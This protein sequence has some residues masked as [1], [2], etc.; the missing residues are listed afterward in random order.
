VVITK[1]ATTTKSPESGSL[2]QIKITLEV[3]NKS[4][5]PL[6]GIL[7]SDLVPTIANV[8]RGLELGTLKP[9]EIKQTR[10]GTK[11]IWSL[12]ELDAHEHRI[13]TYKVRSKLNILGTFSLPRAV[14]EYHVGKRKRKA[15]SSVFKVSS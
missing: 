14:V 3:S 8:E 15:Y 1:K 7:I 11:V 10:Q 6:K 2:S 4:R 9:K 13:M 5:H 12:A